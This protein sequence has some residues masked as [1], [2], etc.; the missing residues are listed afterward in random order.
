MAACQFFCKSK[1]IPKL[2]VRLKAEV[3]PFPVG[4]VPP[5]AGQGSG[6][7]DSGYIGRA[8]AGGLGVSSSLLWGWCT[9]SVTVL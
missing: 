5:Q 4:V 1:I 2:Q 7:Q 6:C 3:L 8:E 9:Q